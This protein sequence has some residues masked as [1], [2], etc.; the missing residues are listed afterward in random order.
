MLYKYLPPERRDI[1]QNG[2]L[3][4]TQPGDFN[5]PFELHPSFDLMSKADIARL[6]EAPGQEGTTGPKARLLTPEALQ[7]MFAAILPG[8][9]RQMAT[10]AG[11]EGTFA[12]KNNQIA[13]S[14]FDSKFGVLSLSETPDSLLMWAHYADSHRGLVLQFDET[15]EFFAPSTYEDQD[16]RLTKVEY[17]AERPVLSY[18]TLNSPR[19]Y[20]RKSPEWSY[21]NEW[22]LVR[23][24]SMATKVLDHPRFPRALFSI[25]VSAVKG[26]I[27]GW[28]IQHADRQA[29]FELLGQEH[30]KH[31]VIYQTQLN[32]DHYSL[33]IHP[34]LSGSYPPE[35]M[36]GWVARHDEV[37]PSDA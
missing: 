32:R 34:P 7:A 3:R 11:Q 13:Q 24:L 27:V 9:Q 8:L 6:P 4:F 21:E 18:S 12:L 35:A 20:Y 15:H 31:V 30:L 22:R 36:S 16:L 2:L 10:H 26:V 19:L 5:D 23:P 33:E 37:V 1:L 25:P 28:A 14:V 17:S 29:L